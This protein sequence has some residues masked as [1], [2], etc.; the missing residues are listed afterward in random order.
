MLYAELGPPVLAFF[1][2][3]GWARELGEQGWGKDRMKDSGGIGLFA[4]RLRC[5][6]RR[7]EEGLV[8]GEGQGS[9]GGGR[10]GEGGC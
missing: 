2:L 5:Q 8:T 4:S 1:S 10:W 9:G 7:G 3:G 6:G